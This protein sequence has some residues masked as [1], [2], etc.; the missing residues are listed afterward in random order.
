[1]TWRLNQRFAPPTDIL[2]LPDRIRVVVEIAGMQPEHLNITLANRALVISGRRQRSIEGLTAYH[3]LEIGYGDF[4]LEIALPWSIEQE[5]VIAN[6]QDGFLQVD[7]PRRAEH[8][9]QVVDAGTHPD[10]ARPKAN[11]HDS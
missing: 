4:R 10:G 3:Q 2:E 6:Y 5:E 11:M 9:I 7:L 1:M 8:R